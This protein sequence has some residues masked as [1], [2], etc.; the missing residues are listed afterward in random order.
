VT[1]T[2]SVG[3]DA[4]RELR[5]TRRRRRIEELDWF[6]AAYRAYLAG[7]LGIVI[8]L[9][10]SSWLGDDPVD[11]ATLADVRAYGPAVVGLVVALALGLGL[12]SGSRGGPLALEAAEVRFVLLAPVRRRAA[13]FSGALRSLRHAAFLGA[14]VGAVA[15]QL[16]GRR[17]TGSLWAWAA[18]GAAAGALIAALFVGAAMMASGVRLRRWMATLLAAAFVAWAALDIARIVSSPTTTLGSLAF[19]PLDVSWLDLAGVATTIAIVVGGLALLGRLSLEEAERRTALVGQLRFAVTLQDLRTVLVLRRQLAQDLPR[20][21]PWIRLGG[22]RR[23]PVWQRD[24]HGVLRFPLSRLVRLVLLAAVAGLCLGYAYDGVPPL[25]IV[26]G[27]CFF[28]TGLEAAEPLAQ[29]IDQADRTDALPRVRG[30]LLVRH[31]PVVGVVM[32]ILGAVAGAAMWLTEPSAF[33]LE[34]A[35]IAAVPAALAGGAGGVV[36]ITMG[37]PDATKDGQLLPPEVAG[38]KIALRSALPV[39]IAVLGCVPVLVAHR[40]QEAVDDGQTASPLGAAA[41]TAVLVVLVS[42]FVGAYVRFRD[43]AHVWWQQ[44]LEQGQ[45]AS[46]ER[47]QARSQ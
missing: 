46:K 40:A 41:A 15:G 3:V 42:A 30:D 23:F 8:T 5:S 37:A 14:V 26:A 38:M 29:D 11:A 4:L 13:L 27:L 43:Q 32:A 2:A 34:L 45:Q 31:L 24:W 22:A 21:R 20:R 36:N 17:L 39:I 7:I 28:L 25:I 12:R 6:E 44:V 10:L 47:Q 1:E 19:W 18:S 35:A 9:F 16:A 33:T